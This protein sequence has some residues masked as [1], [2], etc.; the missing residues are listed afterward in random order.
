MCILL[1]MVRRHLNSADCLIS[2]RE[3]WA[4]GERCLSIYSH[5]QLKGKGRKQSEKQYRLDK[6]SI[7]VKILM[8]TFFFIIK[9]QAPGLFS[10]A[11]SY[12][13]G[14]KCRTLQTF[15]MSPSCFQPTA[16]VLCHQHLLLSFPHLSPL[17]LWPHDSDP[18]PAWTPYH[19]LIFWFF[20]GKHKDMS[21]P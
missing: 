16:S 10:P 9:N 6:H 3:V 12:S 14:K 13:V 4:V 2:K 7:M 18:H 21:I 17:S 8:K 19:P 1:K 20:M 11:T 5:M 15:F